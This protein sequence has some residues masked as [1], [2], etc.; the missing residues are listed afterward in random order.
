MVMSTLRTSWRLMKY[1][2][3]N[4]VETIKFET[5]GETENPAGEEYTPVTPCLRQRISPISSI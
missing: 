3:G 4:E 1:I 2:A 5:L